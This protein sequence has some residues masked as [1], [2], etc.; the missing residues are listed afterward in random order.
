MGLT[1]M[2]IED[3]IELVEEKN[4]TGEHIEFIGINI[5]KEFMPTV[6][7]TE[8]IDPKKYKVLRKNRFV[9][10][11]MQTGRDKCIRIGLFTQNKPVIVS[12]AYT[13]FEIKRTDLVLP[14]Y[15]FMFFLSKEMDRYGWFLSDSS[16]RSNLD[17]P[18][19]CAI[20]LKLPSI[21]IQQKIV[22]TYNAVNENLAA[23]NIGLQDLK[24]T[25]QA[26]IEKLALEYD[27]EEIG[28][29]IE[30]SDIRNTN[31]KVKL[32][33]GIS[34]QKYFQTPVQIGENKKAAKIVQAGEFGWNKAT[35]RNGEKISIALRLG[36]AC[37]VSS[38]YGVFRIK[39]KE[40]LL[41]EYLMLW[42]R[43]SEFDRYAR[44]HSKGSA[45]EFFEFK[46]M[47]QV[48]IPIPPLPIQQSIVDIYH[49]QAERQSITDL[50]TK[51]LRE[52]CPILIRQSL[53]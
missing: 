19:F 33:Q 48:R 18:R 6:A 50:L 51:T 53:A 9:F 27:S 28:S 5:S 8:E 7:N 45:H 37:F 47:C 49:A 11:G 30:E 34:N 36:E 42:F 22:E 12:P 2:I 10:S 25:C 4:I 38:A 1:D 35:T 41:P 16:V 23:Y 31:L 46:D 40:K 21:T 32:A 26:Y 52:I 24:T 17:W 15:F 14:E 39:N 13:T 29:Y 3:L 20:S 43:R 44:Y